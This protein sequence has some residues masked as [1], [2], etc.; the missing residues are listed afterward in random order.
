MLTD[1]EKVS[2]QDIVSWQPHG[3]AFCVHK[4]SEF[5]KLI[6]PRYFMQTQYKSFQLQL[7]IYGFH[8]IESGLDKGAYHHPFFLRSEKMLCLRMTRNKGKGT[9]VAFNETT[10]PLPDFDPKVE[11]RLL[12]KGEYPVQFVE[13]AENVKSLTGSCNQAE[14]RSSKI[15]ESTQRIIL[16]RDTK[17]EPRHQMQCARKQQRFIP[18]AFDNGQEAFFEGKRFFYVDL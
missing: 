2:N 9:T 17:N 7:L 4:P 18:K 3:K 16:S 6:M 11:S 15:V 14:C 12:P 8:R 10:K 13:L 5:V 1:V